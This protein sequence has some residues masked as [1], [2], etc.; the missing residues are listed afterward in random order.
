MI[1]WTDRRV[2]SLL[3]TRPDEAVAALLGCSRQTVQRYRRLAGIA[4]HRDLR[5][6]SRA[7]MDAELGTVPDRIIAER[8]RCSVYTVY[9]RREALGIRAW[10]RSG[11][12]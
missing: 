12:K 1:D 4:S 2:L 6:L 3:G 7:D 8:Y 10:R 9:R 5:Q 11:A